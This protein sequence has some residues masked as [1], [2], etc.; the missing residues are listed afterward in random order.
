METHSYPSRSGARA[1]DLRAAL[2][3]AGLVIVLEI[4]STAI[5]VAGWLIVLPFEV[6]V[7]LVQGILAGVFLGRD[8]RYSTRHAGHFL[9]IGAR[10]ALW[11]G[12]LS[13]VVSLLTIAVMVPVTFGA[14]L[15]GLPALAVTFLADLASNVLFSA[16]GAW[17]YSFSGGKGAVGLSCALAA[18]LLACVWLAL[19]V[20][21]VALV[22]FGVGRIPPVHL[23]PVKLPAMWL[24]TIQW[25]F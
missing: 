21:M 12:G 18:V 4:A 2:L 22:V 11:T 25:P 23:P 17:I 3:V 24:P 9:G 1:P 14:V 19:A 10:S 5:P 6:G 15:V 8:P 7:Y 16:L 20:G 13:L